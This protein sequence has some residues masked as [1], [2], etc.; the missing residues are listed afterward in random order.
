MNISG[1]QK[2][3]LLD[4]PGKIAAILFTSGCNFNCSYCQN[5][6]LINNFQNNSIKEEEILDYLKKRK[7]IIDG[8]VISGGEPT[9]QKNLKE[10]IKK[11]KSLNILVKLDTNGSNPEV[12]KE[13]IDEKLIDYIA[14]DIKNDI[15]NYHEITKVLYDSSKIKKSIDIIKKTNIDHEFRTTVIKNYHNLIGLQ[16]ICKYIGKNEKYYLQNF[17]DSEGVLDK[18]LES[19]KDE[20]L[21][22]IYETLKKDYP[23]IM[24]RGL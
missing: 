12:L 11:I 9:I 4:Y 16:K 22:L 17:K 23:L 6:A 14:M 15:D 10:F 8:I 2:L 13:L 20:E 7:K 5:S 19:Y 3:T 18:S 1:F 21:R 24:V